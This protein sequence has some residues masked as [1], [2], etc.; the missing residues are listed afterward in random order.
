M[1]SSLCLGVSISSSH[2]LVHIADH[3]MFNMYQK[4]VFDG[5]IWCWFGGAGLRVAP[6]VL[7]QIRASLFVGRGVS[8]P[9]P[10]RPRNTRRV[11]GR[12]N[13]PCF[14]RLTPAKRF[15]R[16]VS[17]VIN[18]LINLAF[19]RLCLSFN[20]SIHPPL[21]YHT[22]GRDVFHF[23]HDKVIQPKT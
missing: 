5:F 6:S 10:L 16:I 2:M 21:L 15:H 11:T 22:F 23:R 1:E 8:P 4:R 7:R 12:Q 9:T 19:L 17:N 3:Y 13:V 18:T 14:L 20:I